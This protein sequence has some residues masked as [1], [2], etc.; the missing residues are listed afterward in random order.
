MANAPESTI[1]DVA[2]SLIYGDRQEQYG[3]ALESFTKIADGWTI[4]LRHRLREGESVTAEESTLMMD[5]LKTCRLL[6]EPRHMDSIIDKAGYSG[7]YEKVLNDRDNQ[8]VDMHARG[9]DEF[10]ASMVTRRIA[11]ASS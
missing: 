5:W 6:N 7:C 8:D 3:G 4:I 1:L 11:D 2:K 10:S 9:M